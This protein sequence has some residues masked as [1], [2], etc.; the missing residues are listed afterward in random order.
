MKPKPPCETVYPWLR[1]NLGKNC[2]APLTSTD[3]RALSAAVQIVELYAYC[4]S[5]EV[6]RAFGDVVRCMQSSTREFAYHAIAHVMDW[7]DRSKIW[8]K[9]GL[10]AFT[11]RRCA[12][13]GEPAGA[14]VDPEPAK[15]PEHKPDHHTLEEARA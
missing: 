4:H 2:L 12:F 7:S 9:A 15:Y 1:A 5:P 11:P 8:S 13:E 10:P 6:A 14:P 3:A